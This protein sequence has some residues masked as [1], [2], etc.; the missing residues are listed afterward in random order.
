MT[1][2][3][4][5]GSRVAKSVEICQ[6]KIFRKYVYFEGLVIARERSANL[7]KYCHC[8]RIVT[9][10]F[11]AALALVCNFILEGI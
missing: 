6:E 1:Q 4:P 2:R 5:N 11:E 8:V 3:N 10:C 9:E 7:G